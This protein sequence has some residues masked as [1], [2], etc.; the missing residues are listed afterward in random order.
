[1]RHWRSGT[2]WASAIFGWLVAT[3]A[4]ALMLSMFGSEEMS[5]AQGIAANVALQLLA[6]VG[7]YA[8]GRQQFELRQPKQIGFPVITKDGSD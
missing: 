5:R 2:F 7:G 1:M 3:I 8:Y 6:L 4:L